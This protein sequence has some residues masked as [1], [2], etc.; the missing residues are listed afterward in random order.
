MKPEE[1]CPAQDAVG[2]GGSGA[3]HRRNPQNAYKSHEP[4]R[5]SRLGTVAELTL[6]YPN[7]NGSD[8]TYPGSLFT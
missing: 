4:P 2:G 7:E 1:H 3:A 5:I 8:A 6:G